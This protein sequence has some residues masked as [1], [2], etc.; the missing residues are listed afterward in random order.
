MAEH[1]PTP[2]VIGG[3]DWEPW[4]G[5][6][7]IIGADYETIFWTPSGRNEAANA[8][9]IVKAVNSHASLVKALESC[10]EARMPGEARRIAR[11]ALRSVVGGSSNG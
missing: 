3:D 2:W 6:I 5:A 1:A 4:K 8:A 11:E 10:V 7:S 9:F